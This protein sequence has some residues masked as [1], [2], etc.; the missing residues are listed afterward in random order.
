MKETGGT[1]G[2]IRCPAPLL[3]PC[4]QCKVHTS[5]H[6]A[7]VKAFYAMM[8]KLMGEKLEKEGFPEELEKKMKQQQEQQQKQQPRRPQL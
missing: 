6:A 8:G 3:T 5:A 4:S 1:H 7:Q 2:T